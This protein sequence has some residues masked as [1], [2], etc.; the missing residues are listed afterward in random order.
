MLPDPFS[1]ARLRRA[2]WTGILNCLAGP[3]LIK[4]QALPET[5]PYSG[6]VTKHRAARRIQ[7]GRFLQPLSESVEPAHFGS[8]L[9]KWTGI[10]LIRP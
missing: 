8:E 5:A 4:V 7:C 3:L 10:P 9:S 6:P 1:L 2:S